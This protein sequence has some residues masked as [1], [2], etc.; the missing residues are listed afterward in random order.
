MLIGGE[1]GLGGSRFF[2]AVCG[3]EVEGAGAVL[4]LCAACLRAHWPESR[5]RIADLHA[6]SRRRFG[7]PQAPPR[8]PDGLHC[9]LCAHQCR[10]RPGESGYCGVRSGEV[11]SF[12]RDGRRRALVSWYHDPLPTNC[13]ADWVCPGGTGAGFP[14]Y[15]RDRGPEVGYFNL[16]VFFESCNFNC[17][18][19]QNWTFKRRPPRSGQWSLVT[20][21]ARAVTPST[22]CLCFFGG[23]PIPQLPFALRSAQLIG[24]QHPQ[25]PVRICW[26]T[27]G[28]THPGWL[29]AMARLSAATGGCVK[30]DL[31]AWDPHIHEALCGFPNDRVLRNFELLAGFARARPDPP[32]VVASTLLVPGYVGV[33]EVSGLAAFIARLDPD[34]PYSLLGFAPQF[35]FEQSPTASRREAE[36]CLRAAQKAGLR[37]VRLANRHLL[38]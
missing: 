12:R 13:V 35:L 27:N 11:A 31:K 18:Y 14:Q 32:L 29:R 38:H 28:A 2:C 3:C 10:L 9:A 20:D 19:C 7:L 26:E 37:R 21:L 22:S 33:E 1:S 8:H 25:R 6:A 30:V 4:G 36:A 34:I 15:A 5:D 16:A 24:V 23:D 17:L